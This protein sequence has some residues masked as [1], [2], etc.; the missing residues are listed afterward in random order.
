MGWHVEFAIGITAQLQ[1]TNLVFARQTRGLF[2]KHSASTL[3]HGDN[4][5]MGTL[6]KQMFESA[7]KADF[8]ITII[9]QDS[10][11]S[12]RQR[13]S[14]A[15]TGLVNRMFGLNVPYY[16]GPSL[17]PLNRLKEIKILTNGH[18]F[19]AETIVRLMKKDY[20]YHAIEFDTVVRTEGKTK[21]FRIK[22]VI[23]VVRALFKLRMTV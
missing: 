12:A 8:V 13:I 2:Q 7:G 1:K 15:F 23:S 5:I 3:I 21:A 16:N 20:R 11:S 4:E 9:R 6:M 17:I 18:A 10:R 19:M 22:N 14:K